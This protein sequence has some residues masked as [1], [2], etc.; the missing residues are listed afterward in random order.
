MELS[1][2]V[3]M[4]VYWSLVIGLVVFSFYKLLTTNHHFDGK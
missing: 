2:W 1:G 4:M 3:M